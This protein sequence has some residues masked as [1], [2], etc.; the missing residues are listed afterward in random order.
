MHRARWY[1]DAPREPT[2]NFAFILPSSS[3]RTLLPPGCGSALP[4]ELAPTIQSQGMQALMED[5]TV[6]EG[7]FLYK[8]ERTCVGYGEP[9]ALCHK[10]VCRC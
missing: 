2:T 10:D 9:D 3:L 1:G 4:P 7:Q 8:C 6:G 5:I